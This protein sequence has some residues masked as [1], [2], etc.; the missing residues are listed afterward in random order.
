MGIATL[1]RQMYPRN[2]NYLL[3]SFHAATRE[4]DGYLLMDHHK[5]TTEY[6]RLRTNLLQGERSIVYMKRTL[7]RATSPFI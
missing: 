7:R 5:L 1:T 3:E 6:K 2:V 4:P